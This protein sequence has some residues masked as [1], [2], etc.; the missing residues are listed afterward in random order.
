MS[1]P[2]VH[3]AR[4]L[5]ILLAA[6]RPPH[7]S[8]EAILRP[9]LKY[10]LGS[11]QADIIAMAAGLKP[12][13]RS[14][15]TPEQARNTMARYRHLRFHGLITNDPV[16]QGGVLLYLGLDRAR[17]LA[18][19]RADAGKDDV[20]LGRLLGYPYCCVE[21]FQALPQPHTA[22][23]VLHAR[24]RDF[25]GVGYYRLNCIDLHVFHY[26]PWLPCSPNCELSRRYADAVA[27]S[28]PALASRVATVPWNVDITG[29]VER[30]DSAL[31]AHRLHVFDGVQVSIEGRPSENGV[32][33]ETAWATAADRHPDASLSS[34]EGKA[35]ACLVSRIN[36]GWS[37]AVSDH[38]MLID[39]HPV[40]RAHHLFLAK[41]G[42][43]LAL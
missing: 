27:T 19:A 1:T 2:F 20:E 26:V 16:R 13:M 6:Y 17:V 10:P 36:A 33:R 40:F 15:L 5:A 25:H 35:I 38:T 30:V 12:L 21:A 9:S 22:A 24:F 8:I 32:E 37:I 23:A 4:E 42:K 29:F 11:A 31:A 3:S 14:T 41:F 34:D 39:G 43:G 7:A 28:L 18:A